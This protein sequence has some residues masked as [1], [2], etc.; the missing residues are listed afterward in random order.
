[1][2]ITARET[3]EQTL[4]RLIKAMDKARPVTITYT[5]ADATE[6]IRTIEIYDI[7]TS[8]AGDILIK[9][10]DRET[11][12]QRT[13]RVDRIKSY[14]IHTGATYQV[15]RD[16]DITPGTSL[17]AVIDDEAGEQFE[18][19]Q[20]VTGD[21]EGITGTGIVE[22]VNAGGRYAVRIGGGPLTLFYAEEL[23]PAA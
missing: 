11:Q 21:A 15:T 13:F 9:A 20:A 17:Q 4:T 19:G 3:T 12:E 22:Y 2:R 18:I 10:M 1:M 6:T 23:A 8:A 14:T 7:T 16:D 5:R